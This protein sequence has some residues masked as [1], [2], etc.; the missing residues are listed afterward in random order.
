[1]KLSFCIHCHQPVGNFDHVMLN[2]WNSCYRPLIEALERH[3]AVPVGIHLSGC[4]VEWLGENQPD[5]LDLVGELCSRGTLE[6]F[7]SGYCEPVLP[8]W[9]RADVIRQIR[10]FGKLMEGIS[11]RKPA[12]LW[13]TERVWEPSLASMIAEA[14]I[15]YTVVDDYHLIAGGVSPDDLFRPWI[16]EDAGRSLILLPSSRRLRY[17]IPFSP[18]DRIRDELRGWHDAGRELAFY[19]DDGEKFGVWPGTSQLCFEKGWLDSFLEFLEDSDWLEVLLPSDAVTS[20]R[21]SGPVY[22]PTVSYREMGEWTLSSGEQVILGNLT[23]SLREAGLLEAAEHFL[24]GGT[25]RNFLSRYTESNE[26]HKRVL[27]AQDAVYRSGSNKA[28]LHFWRSQCNCGYWHGV[29]GGLYLPHLREALWCE[30]HQAEREAHSILG[31]LPIIRE[32]DL[33][34]DGLTEILVLGG[35]KSILVRPEMGLTVSELSLVPAEGT[36]VPLGHV[37]SRSPEA[38]HTLP[39][40]PGSE[41]GTGS[42]HDPLPTPEAELAGSL[43]YDSW[44]RISFS[45][46]VLP[47]GVTREDWLEAGSRIIHF[48]RNAVCSWERHENGDI[49]AFEAVL[50]NGDC[51]IEKLLEVSLTE[52]L[53]RVRSDYSFDRPGHHRAGMEFC[54]NLLTGSEPD[55]CILL[56]DKP[57]VPAGCTGASSEPV[58]RILVQDLWRDAA[59][60]IIPDQPADVWYSPLYSLSR[61]EKGFEKIY[62]GTALYISA[63]GASGEDVSIGLNVRLGRAASSVWR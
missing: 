22:I 39:G 26:L 25:W 6:L 12:G 17:M 21:P 49:I 47:Q 18:V 57:S 56:D 11:G 50:E 5:F 38:Y 3:P 40:I 61:S 53:L 2:A 58:R 36:P 4:L 62:Q 20:T 59:V 63:H 1:L 24:K 44:R 9:Q 16:T 14:G 35:E 15:E 29:F 37:L 23:G 19:G 32:G 46:I 41:N 45:D 60:E 7:S 31:D 8:V 34:A 52:P 28:L 43:R 27:S 30:L 10:E 42:I 33:D 51:R 48:Q 54:F 55:R 13:L